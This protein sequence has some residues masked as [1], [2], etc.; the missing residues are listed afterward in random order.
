M[1]KSMGMLWL[2][3]G[4]A[5]L[6]VAVGLGFLFG[7][8]NPVPWIL[9]G[10]L[11]FI[12]LI[13]RRM[14]DRDD[15]SWEESYSVGV[16]VLDDDHKKLIQLLNQFMTAYKYHTGEV[17]ER[18]ALM[19][20]V[21]YTKYHFQREEAML[22]EHGYPDIESHKGQHI[23]MIAEVERFVEDYEVRGHKALEGVASYLTGWL[24]NHINGT[25]KQYTDFFHQHEVN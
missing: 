12:P 2:A 14:A 22:E 20:L 24:I 7:A 6:L 10:I 21:D 9:I 11:L 4:I 8:D 23:A 25:D 19:E 18:K 1:K 3:A 15:L 5:L 13:Y 16:K 17:F